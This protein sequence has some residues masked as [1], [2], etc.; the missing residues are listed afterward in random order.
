MP[1][2][3]VIGVAGALVLTAI[4]GLTTQVCPDCRKRSRKN[5]AVCP[6]CHRR[7]VNQ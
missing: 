1:V 6:H 5:A 2:A 3:I 4:Y 7:F